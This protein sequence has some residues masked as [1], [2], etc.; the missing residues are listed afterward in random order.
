[1]PA[2]FS[3]HIDGQKQLDIAFKGFEQDLGDWTPTWGKIGDAFYKMEKAHFRTYD[4]APLSPRYAAQKA[5]EGFKKGILRKTDQL[6]DSLTSA[7]V[8]ASYYHVTPRSIAIGTFAIYAIYHNSTK[9]RRRLPRRPLTNI[10]DKDRRQFRSIVQRDVV[11]EAK[12]RGFRTTGVVQGG[13]I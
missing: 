12:R 1:M 5:R 7:N 3:V 4:F 6:Y 11:A 2:V 13:L 10:T 9:P 8:A